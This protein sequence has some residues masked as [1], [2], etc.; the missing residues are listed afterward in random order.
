MK[1]FLNISIKEAI[2]LAIII[3]S[4]LENRDININDI[5]NLLEVDVN[6]LQ[7]DYRRMLLMFKESIN[8][9]LNLVLDNLDNND[10]L[11]K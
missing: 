5:A 2:I 3:L 9:Y 7:K 1:L 8:S 4:Y 10:L 6:D 11:K